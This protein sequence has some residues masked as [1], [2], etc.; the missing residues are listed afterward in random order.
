MDHDAIKQTFSRDS[1]AKAYSDALD[2]PAA[3]Y[4]DAQAAKVQS[5]VLSAME[6]DLRMRYRPRV[7][8]LAHATGRLMTHGRQHGGFGGM[9]QH[10]RMLID[11]G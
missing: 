1:I 9:L 11:R 7:R 8:Q 2:N 10:V 6:R 5:D 3:S 4:R